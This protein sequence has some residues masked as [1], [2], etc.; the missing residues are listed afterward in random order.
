MRD[1]QKHLEED[2]WNNYIIGYSKKDQERK[3]KATTRS[4]TFNNLERILI[5]KS[6]TQEEKNNI[7]DD[8]KRKNHIF[9]EQIRKKIRENL[10]KG[11]RDFNNFNEIIDSFTERVI[12]IE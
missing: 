2:Y 5:G 6:F 8:A 4:A 3:S 9:A 10:T 1:L 12:T 7:L 11:I